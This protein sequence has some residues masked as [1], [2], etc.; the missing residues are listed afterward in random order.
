MKI[1]KMN[2]IFS[3]AILKTMGKFNY[4]LAILAITA[5]SC[6]SCGDK[7]NGGEEEVPT[8]GYFKMKSANI[9]FKKIDN[10]DETPYYVIWDNYGKLYRIGDDKH[11][12][13]IDET[14]GK[15]FSL[16]IANKRW[17]DVSASYVSSMLTGRMSMKFAD[18]PTVP[19]Y[20]K[21]PNRTVAGKDC[22]VYSTTYGGI[23]T[24]LGGWN[25]IKLLEE[26]TGTIDGTSIVVNE[27]FTATSFSETVPANSFVVPSDYTKE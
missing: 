7:N 9:T 8:G 23:T 11:V 24:V 12:S 20:K 18:S 5:M 4:A 26:Q 3:A 10:G 17:S 14:T 6:A 25:G 21:L 27:S 2:K 22:V 1:M 19:G 13:V 16:S 15:G